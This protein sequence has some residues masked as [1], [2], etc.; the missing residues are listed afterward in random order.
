MK[1][2]LILTSILSLSAFAGG[3][4]GGG[5]NLISP[6]AP[7]EVQDVREIRNIILGSEHL[8]K[9]FVNAKYALYNAGS[10][11]YDSHRMYSVLFA[12][13]ED[14]LHETMEEI[15]LDVQL[16]SPCYDSNGNIFDGSTYNQ[17]KHTICISAY[18]IAQK[19]AKNE[20]PTQATALIMHEYSEVVGLSDDDA[21]ALQKQVIAELKKW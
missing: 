1:F 15:S 4:S 17:K 19:C 6:S 18:S 5:G 10:M 8:L 20:V 2:A 7:T 11:D 13:N 3:V 12:D 16:N 14:N 21:I 9:K